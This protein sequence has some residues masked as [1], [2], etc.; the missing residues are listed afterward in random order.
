MGSHQ[1]ECHK[2]DEKNKQNLVF[3]AFISGC[4]Q[5]FSA[6]LATSSDDSKPG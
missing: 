4:L 2:L 6:S 3:M 1:P 5:N